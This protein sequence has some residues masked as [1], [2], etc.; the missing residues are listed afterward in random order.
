MVWSEYVHVLELASLH[1][2]NAERTLAEDIVSLPYQVCETSLTVYISVCFVDLVTDLAQ[3]VEVQ[4]VLCTY[5]TV[6]PGG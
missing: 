2:C 5:R 3:N 6:E 4:R 1:R